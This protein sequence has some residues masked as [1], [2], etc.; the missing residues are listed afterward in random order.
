[1][2]TGSFSFFHSLALVLI[3]LVGPGAS[4]V[5]PRCER[6]DVVAVLLEDDSFPV[7]DPIDDRADRGVID[8]S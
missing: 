1:M 4:I 2:A 8:P 7:A 5:R 3:T 6:D